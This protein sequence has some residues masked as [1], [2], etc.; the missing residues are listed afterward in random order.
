M[1]KKRRLLKFGRRRAR[2]AKNQPSRRVTGAR[3]GVH[4]HSKPDDAETRK[5]RKHLRDRHRAL[6]S[7]QLVGNEIGE[8]KGRMQMMASGQRPVTESARVAWRKTRPFFMRR[9][10]R[11]VVIRFLEGKVR[12]SPSGRYAAGGRW[13]P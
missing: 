13:V 12:V 7:W 8:K 10:V 9:F 11:K 1:T 6:K 4:G 5:V 2:K 3:R